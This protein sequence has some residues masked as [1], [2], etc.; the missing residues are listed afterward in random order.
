MKLL[1]FIVDLSAR[2]VKNPKRYLRAGHNGPYNDPETE[3]RNKSHWL[4]TLGKIYKITGEIKYIDQ[5]RQLS[6]YLVSTEARPYGFSFYHRNS[7]GWDKCNGLI[8]QAWTIEA[9][10]S[11]TDVLDDKKYINVAKEV[12]S[13]HHFNRKYGL[14]NRLEIDGQILSIDDTLNHQLWFAASGSLLN[15]SDTNQ[16]VNRFLD[17][18]TGNITIL[19]NGLI[20]HPI[21]RSLINLSYVEYVKYVFIYFRKRINEGRIA[22]VDQKKIN[23][24]RE[25]MIYKSQGYHQFNMYAFAILKKQISTHPFWRSSDFNKTVDYLISKEFK[26]EIASN[27]YGFSYNPPGFELPFA[28]SVLCDMEEDELLESCKYWINEQLKVSYNPVT[29]MMDRNTQDALTHTARIYELTRLPESILKR[30]EVS[31]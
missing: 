28:M 22:K 23:S 30:V 19:N 12:F 3:V 20:Y 26:N 8:G 21:E 29:R 5:V 13:Q 17:L 15:S 6:D 11:A 1:D 18:L 25:H 24:E 27:S 4:I 10:A 16:Y 31:L 7:S 2:A 9:L 14:W